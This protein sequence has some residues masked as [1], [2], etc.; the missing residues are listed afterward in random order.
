MIEIIKTYLRVFFKTNK[1]LEEGQ[2]LSLTESFFTSWGFILLAS[3]IKLAVFNFFT[4]SKGSEPLFSSIFFLTMTFYDI[5]IFPISALFFIT[6]WHLI[7]KF[8]GH[9]LKLEEDPSTISRNILSIAFSSN[10]AVLIPFMGDAFSKLFQFVLM[11]KAVK[12]YFKIGSAEATLIL[13]M[14]FILTIS[15][16]ILVLTFFVYL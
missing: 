4:L 3:I 1:S 7:L 12:H 14:P 15:F 5:F 6:F 11:L 9:Y 2:V 10:V 8:F 16:Y 13:L